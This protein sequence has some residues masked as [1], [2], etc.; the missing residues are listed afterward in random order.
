MWSQTTTGTTG[1]VRG[2]VRY[3]TEWLRGARPAATGQREQVGAAGR[4]PP[5]TGQAG[6]GR[7]MIGAVDYPVFLS[8]SL[9]HEGRRM[10]NG[11]NLGRKEGRQSR[12]KG[13]SHPA[14]RG[15]GE[16]CPLP[17]SSWCGEADSET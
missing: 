13:E 12:R 17:A 2:K 11:R 9:P 4:A 7:V 3:P 5:R 15:I 8:G 16:R 6:V 1:G 10:R 14:E